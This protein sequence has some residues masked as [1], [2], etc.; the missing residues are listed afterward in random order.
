MYACVQIVSEVRGDA[1]S[2]DNSD[3]KLKIRWF[4]LW[5][6]IITLAVYDVPSNLYWIFL[7]YVGTLILVRGNI[8]TMLKMTAFSCLGGIMTCLLYLPIWLTIADESGYVNEGLVDRIV[9]G[10]KRMLSNKFIQ[11]IS[12]EEMITDFWK[13]I[14]DVGNMISFGQGIVPL[15]IVLVASVFSIIFCLR[16]RKAD[17]SIDTKFII[18]FLS[19]FSFFGVFILTLIQSSL[20]YSRVL[21]ILGVDFVFIISTAFYIA[22]R[23]AEALKSKVALVFLAVCIVLCMNGFILR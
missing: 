11:S 9:F 15:I 8:K 16:N 13:W 23:N 1:D 5:G 21:C 22:R 20:P 10:V 2:R 18:L 6:I 3:K 14:N 19:I 12:R 4:L 7:L 17:K